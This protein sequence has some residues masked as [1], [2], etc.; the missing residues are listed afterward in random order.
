MLFTLWVQKS[1]SGGGYL[2]SARACGAVCSEVFTNTSQSDFRCRT[3]NSSVG[4][5]RPGVCSNNPTFRT[6][7]ISDLLETEEEEPPRLICYRENARRVFV[8]R[9][10]YSMR[11]RQCVFSTNGTSTNG[12]GAFLLAIRTHVKPSAIQQRQR[13]IRWMCCF[14]STS[15]NSRKSRSRSATCDPFAKAGRLHLPSDVPQSPYTNE[16]SWS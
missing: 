6:F 2:L 15:T 4:H 9:C 12:V 8:V 14:S 16:H 1:W 13:R 5:A 7:R 3:E 10:V 11:F